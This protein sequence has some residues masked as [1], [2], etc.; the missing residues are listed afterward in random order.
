[1][2]TITYRAAA[3]CLWSWSSHSEYLAT[4]SAMAS[5]F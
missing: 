5:L 4:C 2:R 1:L 3:R